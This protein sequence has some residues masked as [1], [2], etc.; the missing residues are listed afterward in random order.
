MEIIMSRPTSLPQRPFTSHRCSVWLST[1]V[2]HILACP[3]RFIE[4]S[5]VVV[6]ATLPF[7]AHFC[8]VVYLSHYTQIIVLFLLCNV[9]VH[10]VDPY[11]LLLIPYASHLI[12]F[13]HRRVVGTHSSI[14]YITLLCCSFPFPLPPFIC[15]SW[16]SA[17][18]LHQHPLRFCA[19][20][21]RYWSHHRLFIGQTWLL[22]TSFFTAG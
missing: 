21:T 6:P 8:K 15:L 19:S 9:L 14:M 16:I 17:L 3:F 2:T 13:S 12:L 1:V 20:F 18:L 7:Q 4:Y 5:E 10:C 22:W 11:T